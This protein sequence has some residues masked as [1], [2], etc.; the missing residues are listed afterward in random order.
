[1]MVSARYITDAVTCSYAGEGMATIT[2]ACPRRFSHSPTEIFH[3]RD[4]VET[5]RIVA[6]FISRSQ[7]LAMF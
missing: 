4:V 1:M 5:Q 6:D 3:M 7:E 2:L